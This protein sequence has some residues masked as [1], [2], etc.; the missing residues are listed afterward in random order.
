MFLY[1]AVAH[2]FVSLSELKEKNCCDLCTVK[3]EKAYK[4]LQ[5]R[6]LSSF[7]Y[8]HAFRS[9]NHATVKIEQRAPKI[10]GKDY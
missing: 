9:F 2:W 8:N 10:Y 1:Q 7:I 4:S 3:V 6:T 5:Q